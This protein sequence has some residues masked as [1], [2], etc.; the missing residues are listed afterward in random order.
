MHVASAETGKGGADG[1]RAETLVCAYCSELCGPVVGRHAVAATFAALGTAVGSA[2]AADDGLLRITRAIAAKHLS[3]G[4][5]GHGTGGESPAG[6]DAACSTTP[7][8]L[9]AGA[10]HQL[11]P[12]QLSELISH[13]R[14]CLVCKA[15]G[16]KMDR[17]ERVFAVMHAGMARIQTRSDSTELAL[18]PTDPLARAALASSREPGLEPQQARAAVRAYCREWCG[19]SDFDHAVDAVLATRRNENGNGSAPATAVELL[20]TTRAI[21][22]EHAAGYPR[23]ANAYLECADTPALLAARGNDGLTRRERGEL[24]EHLCDCLACQA[25]EIRMARAQRAFLIMAAAPAVVE[26][27]VSPIE[28]LPAAVEPPVDTLQWPRAPEVS[29]SRAAVTVAAASASAAA[30]PADAEPTGRP[31]AGHGRRRRLGAIRLVDVAIAAALLL[32]VVVAGAELVLGSGSG[33]TAAARVHSLPT[34]VAAVAPSHATTIQPAVKPKPARHPASK[35]AR[36]AARAPAHRAAKK[37]HPAPKHITVASRPAAP[38]VAVTPTAPAIEPV[39]PLRDQPA[40][41]VP[42]APAPPPAKPSS[43]SVTPQQSS[44]PAQTAPTQ[45]ISP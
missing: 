16:I 42:R 40:R 2:I 24:T 3:A 7:A 13:L 8:R 26:A 36:H 45:G 30:V 21:A 10:D 32:A 28:A 29:D 14:G 5:N 4:V 35:P 9:V 31:R 27:R 43:P 17:A 23:P 39:A 34:T 33:K 22:A 37:F 41:V 44:L 19:G 12:A 18:R 15:T 25:T 1:V 38:S 20:R 11:D 6:R